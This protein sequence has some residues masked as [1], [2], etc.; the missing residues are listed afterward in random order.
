MSRIRVGTA[1]WAAPRAV[2][3]RFPEAA[4]GL[5]RYAGRFDAAEINTSFYRSHRP[6]TWRRWAEETPDGFRFAVKAPRAITHERR[7]ADS[8]ALFDAFLEEARGLGDKLG[9]ILVQLPP[10]LAFELEMAEGFLRHVRSVYPGPVAWEPRHE[11][12][13]APDATGPG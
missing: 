7:L 12:W 4:S 9:P 1:G 5:Q 8:E 6:T 2:R 13:F 11:S 10:S 3:D